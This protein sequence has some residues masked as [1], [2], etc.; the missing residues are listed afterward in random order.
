MR[1]SQGSLLVI[2]LIV[3]AGAASAA[4][5]HVEADG[6]GNAPSIAAA[7]ANAAPGDTVL[8]GCGTY[9]E[10]DLTLVSSVVLQSATGQANCVTI[11]A[12]GVGRVFYGSGLGS[13]TVIRGF[14]ITGGSAQSEPY[15]GSGGGMFLEGGQGPGPRVEA[16]VFVDNTARNGAGLLSAFGSAP[17]LH[18]CVFERNQA[19]RRGGGWYLFES[20]AQITECVF[21]GNRSGEEG[22]GCFLNRSN[23]RVS[24]CVFE[25]NDSADG[26]GGFATRLSEAFFRDCLWVR[27]TTGGGFVAEDS[28]FVTFDDC[29]WL[30][31]ESVSQYW[32]LGGGLKASGVWAHLNGCEFRGN[33]ASWGGGLFVYGLSALPLSKV[34]NTLIT[35]NHGSERGGGLY[36]TG[37]VELNGCT[38][39][40][41]S[42]EIGGGLF[43]GGVGKAE[44]SIVTHNWAN[45]ADDVW[46][47]P[48]FPSGYIRFSCSVIDS[49]EE[50]VYDSNGSLILR[51]SCIADDPQFC[52]PLAESD[53]PSAGGDYSLQSGSPCLPENQILCGGI[54]LFGAGCGPVSVE[55]STWSRTKALYR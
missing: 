18:E 47:N 29:R 49:T 10:S 30:E 12:G 15:S 1:L 19:I 4:T 43:M 51:D 42:A 38:V 54:G 34:E 53:V 48:E 39:A 6:S 2:C 9:Y 35:G 24:S 44:R 37:Y 55:R 17:Q 27:N 5:I 52:N 25:E 11:D 32:S 50:S 26:A 36:L 7:L 20:N 31:N 23:P 21:V 8:V 16:C 3:A 45:E 33:Q 40:G 41:N 13:D 46:M 28:C 14:T 22:G